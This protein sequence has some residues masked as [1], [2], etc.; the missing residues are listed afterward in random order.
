[1]FFPIDE[2][3]T[4]YVKDNFKELYITMGKIDGDKIG[5]DMVMKTNAEQGNSLK[6]LLSSFQEIQTFMQDSKRGVL[7]KRS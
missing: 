1:M 2:T 4:N 3:I 6:L 7:L 5:Y